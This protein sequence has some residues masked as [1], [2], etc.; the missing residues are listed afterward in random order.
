[1]KFLHEWK[2]DLPWHMVNFRDWVYMVNTGYIQPFY[3]LHVRVLGLRSLWMVRADEH[4]R[5][6]DRCHGCGAL[7]MVA[8]VE[9]NGVKQCFVCGTRR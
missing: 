6:G 8:E 1:M 2:W 7:W 9:K 4:E 5:G 3:F